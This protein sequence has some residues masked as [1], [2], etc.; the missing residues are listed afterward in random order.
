MAL[1]IMKVVGIICLSGWCFM[2]EKNKKAYLN[3]QA[4]IVS[5]DG[6]IL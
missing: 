1:L 4:L 2:L 3:C 6:G 5:L